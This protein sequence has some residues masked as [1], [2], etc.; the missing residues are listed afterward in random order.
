MGR[1]PYR[2]G[3]A[4]GET[5]YSYEVIKKGG[6][7]GINFLPAER[8]ELI[9]AVGTFSGRDTDKFKEF[10]IEYENG[11]KLDVPILK[12]AYFAY[13]CKVSDIRKFGDHYWIVGDVLLTSKDEE[14][15]LKNRLPDFSKLSIPVH[16]GDSSYRVIS[17]IVEEKDHPFN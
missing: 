10:G 9:Q 4:I 5:T 8:S 6:V 2:Y 15:F 3:I 14:L 1:E 17:D 16:I 11:I 7:F 12:D 13:E